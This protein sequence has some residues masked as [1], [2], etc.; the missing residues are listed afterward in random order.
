MFYQAEGDAALLAQLEQQVGNLPEQGAVDTGPNLVQQHDARLAHQGTSQLEQFLLPTRE[1]AGRL[2][3]QL[4][5]TQKAEQLARSDQ[6]LA[7][8]LAVTAA[9]EHGIQHVFPA[10]QIGRHH[11][12]LDHRQP[13]ELM[14]QL[15]GA[16]NTQRRA[17]VRCQGGDIGA[18]KHHPTGAGQLATGEDIEG[19]RLAGTIGTDQTGNGARLQAD[20]EIVHRDHTA[21]GHGDRIQAKHGAAFSCGPAQAV[22]P[23]PNPARHM[24]TSLSYCRISTCLYLSPSTTNLPIWPV[25]SPLTSKT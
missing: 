15:E 4:F 18:F 6:H 13:P 25:T 8:G 17:P 14:R 1:R 23:C 16:R 5:Q 7:L 9:P 20:A 24:G 11:Q 19:G 21:K 3:R 22:S 10:L 12:V 2:Q